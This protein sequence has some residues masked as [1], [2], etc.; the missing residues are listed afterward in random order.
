MFNRK[1]LL[2]GD[3]DIDQLYK[4]FKY[5]GTPTNVEWPGVEE[6]PYYRN[7]FPQWVPHNLLSLVP[8]ATQQ[9]LD[10]LE[11]RSSFL[12]HAISWSNFPLQ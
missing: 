8:R 10:L 7:D 12:L 4:I 1:P 9:G 2:M 5:F 11:V 3:S 6:F